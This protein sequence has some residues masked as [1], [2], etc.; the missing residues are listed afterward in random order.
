MVR[1]SPSRDHPEHEL[2]LLP[3][4]PPPLHHRQEDLRRGRRSRRSPRPRPHARPRRLRHLDPVQRRRPRR[5]PPALGDRP[6]RRRHARGGLPRSRRV[7]HVTGGS[8]PRRGLRRAGRSGD[9]LRRLRGGLGAAEAP[10]RP[11]AARARPPG[12]ARRAWP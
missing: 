8:A 4:S 12:R 2:D 9:W 3:H 10:G 7:R 11:R 1:W 6:E 5:L